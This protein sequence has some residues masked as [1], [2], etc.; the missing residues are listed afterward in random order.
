MERTIESYFKGIYHQQTITVGL[1]E[2]TFVSNSS[3]I[4]CVGNTTIKIVDLNVEQYPT[5]C[6]EYKWCNLT[7]EQKNITKR[8]CNKEK[9]CSISTII[10]S[11]CLFNGYG[12]VSILYSC[13]GTVSYSSTFENGW[14]GWLIYGINRYLWKFQ[15]G[16][17]RDHTTASA[18]GHYVYTKSSSG[19]RL[20]DSTDLLTPRILPSPKQCLTFWYHM[21][22]RHINTL[23]VFQKSNEHNIELW[24]KSNNQ[25]NKW[26]FQ[27]LALQSIGSYKIIFKAIRGNGYEGDIAI[28]DVFIDNTDCNVTNAGGHYIYLEATDVQKGATSRL[29]SNTIYPGDDVCFTFWYHM[30]GDNMGTLNVYTKSRNITTRHWS[31]S[32]NQGNLWNFAN[33]D[34]ASSEPYTIIFEGICGDNFESDIAL[35]DI[36]ILQRSCSGLIDYTQAC[37]AT[38]ESISLASCSKYYLQLNRTRFV[39][40]P[41]FDNCAAV[42]QDVQAST[43]P[44]C[45][46]SDVCTINLSDVIRKDPKCFQSNRLL[47]EYKCEERVP[48]DTHKTNVPLETGLVIGMVAAIVLLACGVVCIICLKGRRGLCRKPKENQKN[49]HRKSV[50]AS[51]QSES[52]AVVTVGIQSESLADVTTDIQ[53]ESLAGVTAH[54]NNSSN[55]CIQLKT[56]HDAIYCQSEEGT[57]DI[58]GCNRHKEADGNIYSHTVDDVY[59]STIRNRNDD[60]QEDKY[61]HFIGQKTEDLY[62][63]SMRT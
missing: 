45:N 24:N 30:Y 63:T 58:S 55:Q 17:D 19:S 37:H 36:I 46:N 39:F 18:L 48:D 34:I 31:Q 6:S 11:S 54:T 35:D 53:S 15:Q 42:Y 9:S 10:P 20:N 57:Y 32:G 33:F 3:I 59:D 28:D 50:Y 2:K 61:D 40:D 5:T 25:G 56:E 13:T 14:D 52:L 49:D 60:D 51:N 16:P 29:I 43:G 44:I 38:D 47:V 21:Q 12:H 62:D 1:N 7:E 41:E 4:S 8:G 22:G 26:N 23:K 27:S